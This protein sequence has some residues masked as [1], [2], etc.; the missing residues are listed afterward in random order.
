MCFKIQVFPQS[1]SFLDQQHV[2]NVQCL[3]FVPPW[4][5]LHLFIPIRFPSCFTRDSLSSWVLSPPQTQRGPR[6]VP[7]RDLGGQ[8]QPLGLYQ[9][10]REGR[11][12]HELC[13]HPARDPGPA[14]G[15][16]PLPQLL[17]AGESDGDSGLHLCHPH[18]PPYFLRASSLTPAPQIS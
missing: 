9:C 16:S 7:L 17:P 12:S 15:A 5:C 3:S 2:K 8:V 18:R 11:S 6:E 1:S 4:I 14:K 13:P 10:W